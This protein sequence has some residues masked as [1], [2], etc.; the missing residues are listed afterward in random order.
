MVT[1]VVN[2]EWAALVYSISSVSACLCVRCRII[3][4]GADELREAANGSRAGWRIPPQYASVFT[5]KVF[6][7]KRKLLFYSFTFSAS[8]QSSLWM[9]RWTK[10]CAARL[11]IRERISVQSRISGVKATGMRNI[12]VS[13]MATIHTLS[14]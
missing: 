7:A 9:L 5:T 1:I 11:K 13:Y 2:L 3:K 6:G 14:R 10:A 8:N 4:G 12:S